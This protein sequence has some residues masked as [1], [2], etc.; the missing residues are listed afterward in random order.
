MLL[1]SEKIDL[2]GERWIGEKE[3]LK[4][5]LRLKVGS[6]Q[7]PEYRSRN[8]LI[9][10]HMD[11]LDATYNVG[12]SEF[13]LSEVGD[14]DS[15]DDLLI[16]NCARYLLLDWQGV[17]EMIDGKAQA[18]DYTPEKGVLLLQAQPTLYWIILSVAAQIAEG[19][20]K[21]VED[22]VGKS[23]K[24]KN[25]SRSSAARTRRRRAGA[26]NS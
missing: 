20:Q 17:G 8:A 1:L 21:R 22:T 11:K 2:N 18:I 9:R 15:S 12:T 6:I 14:I 7:N 24:H 16:E 13:I 25:G 19:K 10:R 26:A 4:K 5:G 3:G 23:L